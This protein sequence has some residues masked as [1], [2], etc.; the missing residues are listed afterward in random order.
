MLE[1]VSQTQIHTK[2]GI[3]L[4]LCTGINDHVS[5]VLV[6]YVFFGRP[7]LQV[8]SQQYSRLRCWLRVKGW[9][10]GFLGGW[11]GHTLLIRKI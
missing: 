4:G 11:S 1:I 9:V 6:G 8:Y 3:A 7:S 10:I 5:K 2:S